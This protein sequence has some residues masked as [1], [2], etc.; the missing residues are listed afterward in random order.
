[1][2]KKGINILAGIAVLCFFQTKVSATDTTSRF[3][4]A[5]QKVITLLDESNYDEAETTAYALNDVYSTN[6]LL[7]ETLYWVVQRYE[8]SK[9]F[10]QS[11]RIYNHIIKEYPDS[12]Y[13]A[14]ARIGLARV[15][16]LSL[17]A[18]E[19]F[20]EAKAATEKIKVDFSS[21]P[22]LPETLF[23][24]SERYKW[25]SKFEDEKSICIKIAQDYPGNP[26]AEKAKMASITAE[27]MSGVMTGD[28]ALARTAVGKMM[29]DFRENPDLQ[30]SL[31]LVAERC[32]W[33]NRY[34][35]AK[36]FYQK[37][38]EVKPDGA[39]A[40]KARVRVAMTEVMTAINSQD[41]QK[42]DE[43]LGKMVADFNGNPELQ[44]AVLLVGEKYYRERKTDDY[45]EKA[46]KVFRIITEKLP[47]SVVTAEAC[48]WAGD[49]CTELGQYKE[50][51]GYYTR[52]CDGFAQFG[53]F[54]G[55]RSDYDFR[56]R[57]LYMTGQSYQK[58][59]QTGAISQA[60]A[61][62]GTIV[63]YE[64]LVKDFSDS[65][66]AKEA[67][68]LLGR[69]YAGKN[70]WQDSARCYEEYVKRI[71]QQRCPPEV[72]YDLAKAYDG[73]GNINSARD[74]YERFVRSALPNDKRRKEAK[75]RL[76]EL[77]KTE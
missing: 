12:P 49:C 45:A 72:F 40:D 35:E 70:Q 44:M 33:V 63:S 61:E 24:I 26:F 47:V 58:M 50:A 1:M 22:D 68:G 64:R 11:K 18:T 41:Y 23:L 65:G 4:K 39:Y 48:C 2:I 38:A 14:K 56:W 19:K 21:S 27:A 5:R 8:W 59:G 69:I 7:P 9:R 75:N 29:T 32:E 16:V 55:S 42:A 77:T 76:T 36:E 3:E 46:K 51:I 74:N 17:I 20:D 30:E 15:E 34:G 31:C 53:C 25:L 6:P 28:F 62:T 52:S 54:A 43:A 37:A 67:L 71:G 73:M 10:E 13:A 60:E 66:A 57:S